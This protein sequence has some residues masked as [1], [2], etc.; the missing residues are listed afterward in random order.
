[1]RALPLLQL[2]ASG[3]AGRVIVPS[4]PGQYLQVDVTPC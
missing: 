2:L 3:Q 1:M 4:L